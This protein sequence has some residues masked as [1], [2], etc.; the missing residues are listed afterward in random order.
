MACCL[1]A[2]SNFLN[3]CLPTISM[4]LHCSPKK[5]STGNI[6]ESNHYTTFENDTFEILAVRMASDISQDLQLWILLFCTLRRCGTC[7]PS[8]AGPALPA[9]S[10]WW[11][12]WTQFA[13]Y[14][15]MMRKSSAAP[16]TARLKCGTSDEASVIWHL[17]M[18]VGTQALNKS[19]RSGTKHNGLQLSVC[20]S[21]NRH[22][23]ARPW[24][25]KAYLYIIVTWKKQSC[26]RK[27][28]WSSSL[29]SFHGF[30]GQMQ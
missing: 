5:K 7:P 3:R 4:V 27:V 11:D 12:I 22:P 2:P 17:G 18:V 15:W 6:H 10:P 29:N 19:N 21:Y 14:K 1:T 9:R 25:T 30:H 23:I 8:R 28:I 24:L 13:A 16:T 26:R 20:K